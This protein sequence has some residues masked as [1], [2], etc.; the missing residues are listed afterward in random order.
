MTFSVFYLIEVLISRGTFC[1]KPH[2]NQTS[3]SKVISNWKILQN[4]RKQR[5]I[6]NFFWLYLLINAP[7]FRLIPLDCNTYSGVLKFTIRVMLKI[8]V[9]I[10][11][12]INQETIH[13]SRYFQIF[14]FIQTNCKW[15]MYN[16]YKNTKL[17]IIAS[18]YALK[19]RKVVQ[20]S[21]NCK[22]FYKE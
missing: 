2:L 19:S 18:K 15:Q 13:Y 14:Y 3:G 1:W 4:N 17:R 5:E 6:H 20:N 16:I 21:L 8:V 7:D 22:G 9:W 12:G 11:T 10:H